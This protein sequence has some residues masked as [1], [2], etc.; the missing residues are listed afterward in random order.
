MTLTQSED[1]LACKLSSLVEFKRPCSLQKMLTFVRPEILQKMKRNVITEIGLFPYHR[2]ILLVRIMADVDM[3]GIPLGM[4]FQTP[5]W[6]LKHFIGE[7][8]FLITFSTIQN[9]LF[10]FDYSSPWEWRKLSSLTKQATPIEAK[11]CRLPDFIWE[12]RSHDISAVSISFFLCSTSF[13]LTGT[14]EFQFTQDSNGKNLTKDHT[15]AG[16]D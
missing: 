2:V 16:K 12:K 4:S 9:I 10:L 1:S 14:T 5:T 11:E 13:P 15:E 8:E 6:K 7:E 3:S